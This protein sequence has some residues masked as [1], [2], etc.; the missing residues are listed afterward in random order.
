MLDTDMGS[1]PR[2]QTVK[3][4]NSLC[5]SENKTFMEHYWVHELKYL[6]TERDPIRWL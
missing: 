6:E 3:N 4:R 5:R 2:G 1:M